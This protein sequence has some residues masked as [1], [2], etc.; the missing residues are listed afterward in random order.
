M[1]LDKECYVS[2]TQYEI[3]VFG[4]SSFVGQ[5][6]C[7][8]LSTYQ[9]EDTP[10][11]WAMAGRSES[12]LQATRDALSGE[13]PDIILAD[14]NDEASLRQLVEK[15]RVVLS[16]VGP[17]AL[18][19]EPLVKV[20]AETGTDYCDL[21]GEVH[22]IRQMVDRYQTTAQ[23]SGARIVHCCGFDSIPSDLGVLFTQQQFEQ[24]HG[25]PSSDIRMRVKAAKGGLSGGTFASLLN[26]M[27]EA[28]K[29]PALRKQMADPY[30]IATDASYS[31]RQRNPGLAEHDPVTGR[32]MSPFIMAAINTRVVHRS[33]ALLAS[34]YG[35][36]FRYEETM[37]TGKGLS[38]RLSA[39][40]IG[41]GLAAFM[42]GA[43]IKPSRWLLEKL[44]PAPGEGPSPQ[45]QLNGFFD[46][47][48]YALEDGSSKL[49]CK[50]TGDRDPGYGS[51]AKMIS[52]A[53]LCLAR[54]IDAKQCGGGIWT[55][56][57]SMGTTLQGRLES[58]AG[59]RFDVVDG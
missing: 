15:T 20:C 35:E 40:G 45:D 36:N 37:L 3:I 43:A 38:G 6:I 13:K 18:Y 44:L 9:S 52:Q 29:D 56:A 59:L 25:K 19:G 22:W 46:M 42:V 14:S 30:L 12:K 51:T 26:V 41:S 39:Y 49:Q 11:R 55:P 57:S 17:Y 23:Q 32:W 8:Y 16:T 1:H 31:A 27:K 2:E 10:L 21:T 4:A 58:Y 48:F 5:I 24:R 50:V 47:R 34:K 28:S 33:N 7:E 54:D 53:A